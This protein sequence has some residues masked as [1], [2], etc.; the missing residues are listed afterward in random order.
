MRPLRLF[1]FWLLSFLLFYAVSF[2]A[3]IAW[4]MF[5]YNNVFLVVGMVAP[6][7]ITLLFGWLYFRR[8]L[9]VTFYEVIKNTIIWIGL[10]FLAGMLVF[11]ILN[12][13]EPVDVFATTSLITEAANFLALLVAAYVSLKRPTRSAKALP[14]SSGLLPPALE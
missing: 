9:A 8:G 2:L 3:V 1:S 4:E 13:A 11:G 5:G 10:D 6:P 7:L 14:R 12:G